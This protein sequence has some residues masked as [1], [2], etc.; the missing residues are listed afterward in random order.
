[1]GTGFTKINKIKYLPLRY[2]PSAR[3]EMDGW[4]KTSKSSEIWCFDQFIGASVEGTAKGGGTVLQ[5]SWI[6]SS[7]VSRGKSIR[8][9]SR[10]LVDLVKG[11]GSNSLV[12]VFIFLVKFLKVKIITWEWGLGRNVGALT[13]EKIYSAHL[14]KWTGNWWEDSSKI[15]CPT[16]LRSVAIP[17]KQM[18]FSSILLSC[19]NESVK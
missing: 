2:L 7:L 6:C 15:I 17:K 18:C 13:N 12:L 14:K 16:V 11:K 1:M 19:L 5:K 10:R 4:L 3:R 9:G 8:V